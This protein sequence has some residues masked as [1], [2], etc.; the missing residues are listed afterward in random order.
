MTVSPTLKLLAIDDDVHNL[1]II[2]V[3]LKREGLEIITSQD[4]EQGF[5]TFLRMRPNIVL[6]DLVMPKL[7]GMEILERIVSVDPGVDVI[8]ITAHYS[9]ESAVEAIQ[10]GASDY[11]TKPIRRER[12]EEALQILDGPSIFPQKP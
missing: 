3:A 4:A 10:K 6:L 5:E 9:P 12:L 8:L 1:E 2:S 7:S 11:L